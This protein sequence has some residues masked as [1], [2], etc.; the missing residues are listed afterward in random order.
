[1]NAPD[2][3]LLKGSEEG[4][5][6][7][8]R[9]AELGA[10]FTKSSE[11]YKLPSGYIPARQSQLHCVL[12]ERVQ[13]PHE[14]CIACLCYLWH[15]ILYK[16][17]WTAI[18]NTSLISRPSWWTEKRNIDFSKVW[19]YTNIKHQTNRTKGRSLVG[20]CQADAYELHHCTHPVSNHTS[21]R[22]LYGF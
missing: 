17:N 6:V 9:A 14:I 8:Y 11:L 7:S 20:N 15:W 16:E 3:Q 13:N 21:K 10:P 12:K 19:F 22:A 4:R 2:E 1:M 5:N 18:I